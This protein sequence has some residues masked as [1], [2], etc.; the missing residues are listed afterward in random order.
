MFTYSFHDILQT[1]IEIEKAL[2]EDPSVYEYDNI[3]DEMT[4][5]KK[6]AVPKLTEK[7]KKVCGENITI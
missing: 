2:K 1:Q 4:E 5:K 6:A 3:Y 7:D